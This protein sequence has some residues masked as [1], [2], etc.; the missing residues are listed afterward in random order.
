MGGGEHIVHVLAGIE[1]G[2]AIDAVD[3][4][5]EAVENLD[6]RLLQLEAHHARKQRADDAGDQ[7]EHKVHRAD[8][9]VVGRKEVTAPARY[10]AVRVIAVGVSVVSFKCVR[11]GHIR[12]SL[13][14]RTA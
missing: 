1:R 11:V 5:G 7:G 2:V 10:V 13:V 14:T 6:A 8:V 9:L 12:L 3:H 4:G